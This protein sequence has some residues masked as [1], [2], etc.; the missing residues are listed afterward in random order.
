MD[1]DGDES[2]PAD[3]SD[4]KIGE[5]TL[6]EALSKVGIPDDRKAQQQV[7]ENQGIAANPLATAAQA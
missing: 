2:M 4:I 3:L 5:S 6:Q 7:D 1:K